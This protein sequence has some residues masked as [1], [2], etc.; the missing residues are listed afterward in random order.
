MEML[1]SLKSK[2]TLKKH[3]VTQIKQKIE[4]NFKLTLPLSDERNYP[5]EQLNKAFECLIDMLA[6]TLSES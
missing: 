2:D 4:E 1:A 5:F 6:E 3:F